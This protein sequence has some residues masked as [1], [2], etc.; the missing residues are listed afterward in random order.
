MEPLKINTIDLSKIVYPKQKSNVNKKIILIKLNEKNKLKNFV[1]QTPTLLNL[2]K[3]QLFNGYSEIELAMV[4]KDSNQHINNFISFLNN[5][6][7]KIKE[8]AMFNASS[9][10]NKLED[11]ATINFQKIIRSSETYKS[12]TLKIKLIRNNDFETLI[13]LN[14]NK[15]ISPDNIPEDSWCKMILE[16]YAVWVNPNNDF[17]IFFRPIL[18]SFTPK[19][20]EVYNYKFID[21]EENDEDDFEVPDTEINKDNMQFCND[22]FMK[23]HQPSQTIKTN[24][25]STSQLEINNILLNN[26]NSEETEDNGVSIL[27]NKI[28]N[29]NLD[30]GTFESDSETE[31]SDEDNTAELFAIK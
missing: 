31:E 19:E 15:R 10:F 16:A 7:T 2:E 3:A 21:D 29:I 1:F 30:N 28:I 6:E 25:D 23:I 5:M 12:G 24:N 9:W 22:I 17:G 26:T 18:V 8:D 14:N 11:N 20:K 27:N 13:Q 4:G